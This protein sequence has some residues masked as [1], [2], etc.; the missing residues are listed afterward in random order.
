M[1]IRPTYAGVGTIYHLVNRD[2]IYVFILLT[3]KVIIFTILQW[4]SYGNWV[5]LAVK[6][7]GA[8]FVARFDYAAGQ[9]TFPANYTVNDL[10]WNLLHCIMDLRSENNRCNVL[11]TM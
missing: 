5:N 6:Q 9:L 10:N 11:L 3:Y 8:C 2:D 1:L 7:S 4:H